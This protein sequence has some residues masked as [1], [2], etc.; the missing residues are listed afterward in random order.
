M[1]TYRQPGAGGVDGTTELHLHPFNSPAQALWLCGTLKESLGAHILSAM[2]TPEGAVIKVSFRNPISLVDCL[3]GMT[4]VAEV[5]EEAAP[6]LGTNGSSQE[7]PASD[8]AE[9]FEKPSKMIYV[10]LKPP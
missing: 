9:L 3:A 6:Q 4:E 1:S 7:H 2:G 10:A 5:W 8:G